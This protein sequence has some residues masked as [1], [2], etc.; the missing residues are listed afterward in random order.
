MS[1]I[2]TR[3]PHVAEGDPLRQTWQHFADFCRWEMAVGGPD[4]H[5]AVMGHLCQDELRLD[6]LWT[7][8]LYIGFYNVPTALAVR[9]EL[10]LAD[11]ADRPEELAAWVDEHWQGFAFRRERRPIRTPAKLTRYLHEYALWAREAQ[12]EKWWSVSQ[13]GTP[14]SRYE[15]AWRSCQQVSGLGRYVALKL[16]EFLRRYVG[17]P[18]HLPDLRPKGGWSP[19]E[20]LALLYPEDADRLTGG[21]EPRNLWTANDRATMTWYGLVHYGVEL[22]RYTLQVLLCDFKQCAVGRR[23]FPGRSQDS[24]LMYEAKVVDHWGP[25]D[26]MRRA[27][28]E[29]FPHEALGE[30]QGWEKVREELGHVLA[31][32]GYIWSDLLFDYRATTNLAE[33]VLR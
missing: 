27:R 9:A 5:M 33:P 10:S 24:E 30:L 6:K 16:L 4:P 19:R 3:P 20:G 17:A 12:Y 29:L 31:D 18:I 7:G 13:G 15:T 2:S 1:E 28:A 25:D 11:A 22:D 21:D 32:H 26:R 8:G 14:F 23:Q